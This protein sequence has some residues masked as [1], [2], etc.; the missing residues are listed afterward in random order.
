MRDKVLAINATDWSGAPMPGPDEN[1]GSQLK[2]DR[3]ELTFGVTD[4]VNILQCYSGTPNRILDDLE[5]PFS[6]M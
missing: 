6:V 3:V 1:Q 5:C 2:G 4:T